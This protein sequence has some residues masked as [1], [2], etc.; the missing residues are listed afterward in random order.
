[1]ELFIRSFEA[2][3]HGRRSSI[4]R[5][6]IVHQGHAAARKRR[7]PD[8]LG[9]HHPVQ[10]LAQTLIR[11]IPRK[12]VHLGFQRTVKLFIVERL[13][14][15]EKTPGVPGLLAGENIKQVH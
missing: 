3:E 8:F 14:Q 2:S 12:D 13:C 5:R 10:N 6:S 15:V 7:G 1:M 9:L 4:R 11:A